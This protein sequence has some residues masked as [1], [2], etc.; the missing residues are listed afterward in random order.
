M[1]TYI[2]LGTVSVGIGGSASISFSSIASTYTDLKLVASLRSNAAANNDLA[3]I[4]FNGS[5]VAVYDVRWASANG[6]GAFSGSAASQTM[7][8]NAQIDAASSTASTFGSLECYIPNY[9]GSTNKSVSLDSVTENNGTTAQMNIVA[10]LWRNTSVISSITLTPETGLLFNQYS[11]AT[12]YG[13]KN[14]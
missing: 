4:R 5:S 12:L 2:N 13:I 9:T 14:S 10:G 3:Y 7:I 1:S 8:Y 6:S 11:T